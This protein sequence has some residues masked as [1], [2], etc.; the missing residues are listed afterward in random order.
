VLDTARRRV[1]GRY[2]NRVASLPDSVG[3]YLSAVVSK[4]S[5]RVGALAVGSGDASKG[6]VAQMGLNP[7]RWRN[8]GQRAFVRLRSMHRDSYGA[9]GPAILVSRVELVGGL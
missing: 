2:H 9:D 1:N 8:L 6:H 3:D 4:Q 5:R 7:R